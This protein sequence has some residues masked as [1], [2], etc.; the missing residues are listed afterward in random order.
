M[1]KFFSEWNRRTCELAE[2]TRKI[3]ESS[4]LEEHKK[5]SAQLPDLKNSSDKPLTIV[6]AGEYSAGKSSLIKALTGC[7]DIK[8]GEGIVTDSV[9]EYDWNGIKIIDTP[10]IHTDSPSHK[11]H[12]EKAYEAIAK[13]DL[14]IY[15][16]SN[17]LFDNNLIEDFRKLA[18]EKEKANEMM[19]VVNKMNSEAEGNSEASQKAKLED[20]KNYL[21]PYKPEDFYVSFISVEDYFQ[22]QRQDLP[23]MR[24][25]IKFKNSG[26][27]VLD[28]NIL[29]FMHDRGHISKYTTPL[30]TISHVIEKALQIASTGDPEA[31]G[32]EELLLQKKD[33]LLQA[34][35]EIEEAAARAKN[36]PRAEA[37]RQVRNII[38]E[39][40]SGETSLDAAIQ[41]A[42]EAIN[43]AAQRS[44][45]QMSK[46]IAAIIAEKSESIANI[47]SSPY[48]QGI[49]IRLMQRFADFDIPEEYS[50][51]GQTIGY[52]L[53]EAGAYLVKL[54]TFDHTAKGLKIASKSTGHKAI[55]D[56]GHLF[57]VKFRPYQAV[58][59][60]N[61]AR[62]VGL[63]LSVAGSLVEVLSLYVQERAEAKRREQAAVARA[64]IYRHYNEEAN[65]I[66]AQFDQSENCYVAENILPELEKVTARLEELR[67]AK[68][69]KEK[70]FADLEEILR[71]TET[72][73]K[74]IQ[75]ENKESK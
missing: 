59:W 18:F 51:N 73:I 19:L 56:L 37:N 44:A 53:K 32:V 41:S 47:F 21:K 10:G 25:E 16:T 7:T 71:K 36:A 66:D 11:D 43:N 3:L 46:D 27:A 63:G 45:E 68:K 38:S 20:L 5:L 24:R 52:G 33:S 23:A 69:N 48:A 54:M 49:Q 58:R 39:M 1:S 26:K 28:A 4:A 17:T 13:A 15:L 9:R 30:Y 61:T 70:S 75:A 50:S 62:N 2:E 55:L 57:G 74:E 67:Q 12:D 60:A 65:I 31:D 42:D 29:R 34:K 22:S 72:L 14:L 6:F 40:D 8:T 35:K 64:S